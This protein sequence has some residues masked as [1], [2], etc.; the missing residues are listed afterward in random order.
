MVLTAVLL[1]EDAAGS[2]GDVVCEL[3]G[4]VVASRR[5]SLLPL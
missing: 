1:D 3:A 2:D 4:S 5:H